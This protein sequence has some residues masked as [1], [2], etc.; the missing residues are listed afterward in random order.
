MR[1]IILFSLALTWLAATP[2]AGTGEQ[3]DMTTK[4]THE[5]TNRLIDETSPYLR[6]HAHNPVDWYPWG[7]EAF[8]KA[9]REKKPVFLS[10][11]Y[12]ACHWCHVMERE[13]FEDEAIAQKLNDHFVSVKVDREERPDIDNI[14]MQ[15]VQ[16]I[17]GQGGWPM[18]LFLTPEG[19]PFF[20]GT[21]FPPEARYGRIGFSELLDRVNEIYHNEPDKVGQWSDEITQLISGVVTEKQGEL[22]EGLLTV[23]T[24]SLKKRFDAQ[25]GG[26]GG[27]PKFPPAMA[28]ALLL[29]EYDRRGDAELLAMVETTLRK[30]AG[31]G[32]YDHL[33]GGFHRYSVDEHWLAPHFEKMLYNDALLAPIYFDAYHVT[34]NEFYLRI[35]RETLDHVLREMT[36]PAGGFYSTQDAD[37]EGEEGKFYIWRPA[38]IAHVLGE[39]NAE[40][41][42]E[43]YGVT[44]AGNWA[45]GKGRSILN[46]PV[47]LE[48]FA[49]KRALAPEDLR[50]RLA[51]LR[52]KLLAARAERVAPIKDDKVLASWNG[53]MISAMARGAQATGDLRYAEAATASARFVLSRMRDSDGGLLRSWRGGEA[54]IGAFLEDYANMIVGLIDLYETTFD[55]E[56]LREAD[57]LAG[58]MIER[59]GDPKG[60]GFYTTDGRD[61]TVI[62]R[63]KEYFDGAT[64]SGN[65]SAAHALWRLGRLLDRD[66]YRQAARRVMQSITESMGH[67]PDVYH[68]MLWVV[69]GEV[70]PS[71]EVAIV[72]DRDAPETRALLEGLWGAYLP[73]MALAVGRGEDSGLMIGLLRGREAVEGRTTVYVC[74]NYRCFQPV[75]TPEAMMALLRGKQP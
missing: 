4:T 3:V 15:A 54:K 53:M 66:E 28:L 8:D 60:G 30:M 49:A 75:F 43:F 10:I 39:D 32:I 72:G 38:E 2:M 21:Y 26:F 16:L 20:G 42:C 12:S 13:S 23:A 67:L 52:E 1:S 11:G 63:L 62:I 40:L 46:T 55:P 71:R 68:H 57:A 6:Q 9:R 35:G 36:D 73:G 47:G 34:G 24:D 33:G 17:S 64:P 45:E 65:A 70:V 22:S 29:R 69:A 58:R 51:A 59:F 74:E 41:F 25:D 14:Y 56:L 27:A 18:S 7:E 31:G 37:S 48:A 61:K 19:E 50:R 5:F 44:E